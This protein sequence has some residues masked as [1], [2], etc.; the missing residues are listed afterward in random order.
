MS[1]D[2][3]ELHQKYPWNSFS[4]FWSVAKDQGHT[5]KE[6]K[7][8]LKNNVVKDKLKINNRKYFLP[9]YGRRAGV[10]QFDTLIQSRTASPPAF[11]IFIEINSKKGYGYPMKN[12]G[13][14]EVLRCLNK[15]LS[16]ARPRPVE[17]TSDQDSAYINDKIINFMLD[18]DINYFTT[19]DNNHNILGTVNRFIK[20]LRDHHDKRD[21]SEN[22]LTNLIR[23]YNNSEHSAHGKKPNQFNKND[24]LN[25]IDKMEKIEGEVRGQNDFILKPGTKVRIVLDKPTIGKK[26]TNLSKDYYIIDSAEGNGYNIK[27]A[28]ESVAYLPRHKLVPATGAGKLADTLDEGKRGIVEKIISYNLANDKYKIVYTDGSIDEIKSKNMR[29]TNPT[30]ASAMEREFWNKNKPVPARIKKYL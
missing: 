30:R 22:E 16:E 17:M 29:E 18:N 11:L 15:F 12:K 7:D 14:D 26:R 27:S 6:V 13:T 21:F 4:K 10:Y 19:E 25:Y 3:R 8:F 23:V 28:D 2:L 20:T 24:E 5:E 1:K 9:I